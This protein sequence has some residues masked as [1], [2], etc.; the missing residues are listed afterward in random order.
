MQMCPDRGMCLEAMRIDAAS[1]YH[2]GFEIVGTVSACP[3]RRRM[4]ASREAG[5]SGGACNAP[6]RAGVG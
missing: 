5:G 6:Q 2:R 1:A 4:G 3:K